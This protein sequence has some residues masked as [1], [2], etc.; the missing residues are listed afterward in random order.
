MERSEDVM[1]TGPTGE[2]TGSPE[3][4]TRVVGTK[5]CG[6]PCCPECT[7]EALMVSTTLGGECPRCHQGWLRA[8][9]QRCMGRPAMRMEDDSGQTQDLCL[10]HSQQPLRQVS[11]ARRSTPRTGLEV[12]VTFESDDNLYAGLT[13]DIGT[14]GLFVATSVLLPVGT[15]L[16]VRFTLP[17]RVAPFSVFAR[18]QWTRSPRL[19]APDMQPGMGLA[20]AQLTPGDRRALQEFMRQREPMVYEV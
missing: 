7:G 17:G 4:E 13:R 16:G 10:R 5:H 6:V 15:S 3:P 14:G 1:K 11:G 12:E 18:V 19:H 9:W 2:M 20:F 8:E